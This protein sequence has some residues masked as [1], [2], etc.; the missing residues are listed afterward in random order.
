[1]AVKGMLMS[2]LSSGIPNFSVETASTVPQWADSQRAL[3]DRLNDAAEEFVARYTRPDGSLIWREEWPGMDGSDDPYEGFQYLALLYALGG[4]ERV[5]QLARQMWDSITWQWAQYGQIEREF[6]GYYDWM[7]HGEANLFHYFFGL[8][9]PES[10]TERVRADRF[11]RMYTGEDPLAPNYDPELKL[12]RAPQSGSRGPRMRVTKE[13]L[14]THRGVL[15]SYH[16]PF[17]DMETSP[18][19]EGK[20]LCIW[21]DPEVFEEIILLMNQRTTRG[22]VPLNL[23]AS[24]QM[25]HAYMYS[26]DET[27]KTWVLD[28][29]D[30]WQKRSQANDGIMPDNV[31]LSGK[32][33]EY[34]DGKWWGGHYGWRWP[35][36][37]LTIIEPILNTCL[38]AYLMTG[39]QN[40]VAMVREQLDVNF[41]LGKDQD[42]V[43]H[44]PQKHFDSG[45][46]DYRPAEPTYAIHLWARTLAEEDKDRVERARNKHLEWNKV[47]IAEKPF[48]V[49]HYNTNTLPWYEFI[50]GQFP[51]YPEKLLAANHRLIDQQ[52]ERLRSP[53]GDP[54]RW[55]TVDQI[56]DYPDSLSMQVDGYAIHAW[57][58]FNPVYFESLMQLMLGAPA[59]ISHGGLQHSTFRYFDANLKRCG[60]PEDVAALV[61]KIS[62]DEAHV[63]L[64]NTG[65]TERR[66]IIQA[67]AFQEHDFT[68]VVILGQGSS[69][70]ASSPVSG[71]WVKITL[72]P[73]CTASLRLGM[74]RYCNTPS[75]ETPWSNRE[76][77]D[78]IIKPRNMED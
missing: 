38:N 29:M 6:D 25:T 48:S 75:Y 3:F 56:L 13:D 78:P 62:K 57:Q 55:G 77:W 27:L 33:G 21:S 67:G 73:K 32:V 14:G 58:E 71:P 65:P 54:R 76:N 63:D 23:N 64:V 35:H 30:L 53:D 17:E 15:D 20:R 11:A 69:D 31:G 22:D 60:V 39:D 2:E 72:A 4:S 47:T 66:I 41:H 16:A 7:H 34:L 40:R 51:D 70:S 5:G 9:N 74:I 50:N 45:W 68:S 10:L 24:G 18:F 8:T 43:W 28:Y 37:F 12:I 61:H 1:M 19:E 46:A 36:G 52:L 59:H 26:G 49:K 44:T 42:G